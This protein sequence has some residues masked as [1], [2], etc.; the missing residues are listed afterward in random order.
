MKAMS[1][2]DIKFTVCSALNRAIVNAKNN[3][4]SAW[5]NGIISEQQLDAVID[6]LDNAL[7]LAKVAINNAESN[8]EIDNATVEL[9]KHLQD[10][11]QRNNLPCKF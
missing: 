2:S 8:Q 9:K 5:V 1:L 4:A 10:L 11:V 7:S 6:Q 3:I